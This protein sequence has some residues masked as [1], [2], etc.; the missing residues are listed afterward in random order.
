MNVPLWV[1]LSRMDGIYVSILY[2]VWI[3]VFIYHGALP[4]VVFMGDDIQQPSVS[5]PSVYTICHCDITVCP[6]TNVSA[7]NFKKGGHGQC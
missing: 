6:R 4:E 5:D 2:K 1:V 7:S 3:S